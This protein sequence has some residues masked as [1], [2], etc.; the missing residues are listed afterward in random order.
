MCKACDY[1]HLHVHSEYSALDGLSKVEE[2][3][4]TAK[5]HGQKAIAIT[6]HGSMSGLWEAQKLGD[7]HDIK[8]ILGCEFYYERENDGKNGHLVVL[9][10]NNIGLSNMFKMQ[11][12]G[13]VDNFYRK[14][15]INWDILKQHSE[16]LIVTSTCL[17]STFCQYI[18]DGK[19]DLA[20]GWARK[21]Q[22][23]FKDDF[24]LEV[25]P[26]M[27]PE[28]QLVN[29]T[30]A[31]LSH[32]LGI[33]IVATNDVHYTFED[34]CFPHEVMLAMQMNAKM[35][36]DKRFKFDTEDFWLKTA[37]EMVDT[38]KQTKSLSD[39]LIEEALR[40]T[41]EIVEKCSA[42]IEKGKY[43]PHYHT[44]PHGMTE[45]ELLEEETHD[46]IK[47][48]GLETNLDFINQAKYELDVI[49]RNGYSGYFL[50]VQDMVRSAKQRGDLV[51]DGRGSGAGSKVAYATGITE[52][53]PH[54]FDLLFERFMADGREPD[55]DV[56]Y[57]DQD[58]V[59]DDLVSKY[60][61]ANV[62]RIVAFGTLAPRAVI[63][64]VFST[65]EHDMATI[66]RITSLVPNLCPSLDQALKEV[67]QLSLELAK[68]PNEWSVIKRLE[69]VISHESQHAGGVI[70]YPNLS[71]HVPVKTL[72][73]EPRKRIVAW[74]KYMLEEL[75]HF[76]FDVLGLATLPI[77]N[78]TVQ[79][80][81]E[82]TGE[83][84]VLN[85]LD[86][87]DPAVYDMLCKGDVSGVFQLANQAQKVMEQQP[88]NFKD[89][90]AINALVRPGVG[91]WQEYIARRNGKPYEIY[92][93]RKP[94]MEET[95]GTMTYQE[96]FLLDAHILAGWGIAYADKKLR[97]NKDIRNDIDTRT[98]FIE[99]SIKNGHDKS[100]I[101]S[102]WSEIEDAVDGGYSFNKS[103]SASY[104]QTSYQTAWLKVHY[105][106]HFYASQ[107]SAEGTD[108][109]GQSAI[110]GYITELK[111]RGIAVLPPDINT[112]TGKFK[113][114]EE[115]IAYRITTI[116]HV[117]ESAIEAIIA[118]RPIKDFQDFLERRDTRALRKNVIVNLIKAGAF[119]SI[120]P[121]R[122]HL[123][124]EFD[125]ANRT[126]TQIKEGYILPQL[127]YDDKIKMEWEKEVLGMYLSAHP[128]EKY[129]FKP[130]ES[131]PEGQYG[132]LAGGEVYERRVFNDKN[133]NEMAFIFINTLF[134]NIKL[135]CF[136]S[137]WCS[138]W[139]LALRL[140]NT[141]MVKG[142]RS[143]KDLI[144]SSVEVLE[145]G[146]SD[147]QSS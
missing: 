60:G 137:S 51:G 35:S 8:V 105:P 83:K 128:M 133:G 97:K 129:G 147:E 90:I 116:K 106:K 68:Y 88:R 15:R 98:K 130:F 1:A 45:G 24:Y 76:K 93:P 27:L 114:T 36:D 131:Y 71:S 37:D 121:D 57:E 144:V 134:G 86:R 140:G 10:K 85:E 14:P 62:A 96:Q 113:P 109:D 23:L 29:K 32:E 78:D 138:D 66:K 111:S 95:V 87:E 127:P 94:Y 84:I 39:E 11:E 110:G 81:Y 118:M 89:L 61:E 56:D 21:F 119:D 26:N 16:G 41:L 146:N 75:G 46:G 49:E 107:M 58:A 126:K 139:N 100:I 77:L 2:L 31:R 63:R 64:K 124:W 55:F 115:G 122:G 132:A 143:G 103:H 135:L 17:A 102:I 91:D 59:F 4:L 145:Y 99:D 79:S 112:S 9:A 13:Y 22:D 104:A 44:I 43:L 50:I 19:V 108:S 30:I 82:E 74:D 6:D 80:I 38:F 18:L 40:N 136:A 12:I 142:K 28:Q 120:H 53:P 34:D 117:G 72:R 69:G 3:I 20:K 47:K 92:E 141:V 52:I 48:R 54:E 73:T 67:P 70:I 5:S 25:Q 42:R 123:M 33:K 101:E 65:F 7:K 125:M